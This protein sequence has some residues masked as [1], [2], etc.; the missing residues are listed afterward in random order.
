[1]NRPN[2]VFILSVHQVFRVHGCE[3]KQSQ[4]AKGMFGFHQFETCP[5]CKVLADG[6][7]FWGQNG[8]LQ[9]QA[10]TIGQRNGWIK[11]HAREQWQ[12]RQGTMGYKFIVGSPIYYREN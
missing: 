6:W 2:M 8:H 5:N 1:M 11:H 4:E 10:K 12:C 7:Q 9:G 3:E